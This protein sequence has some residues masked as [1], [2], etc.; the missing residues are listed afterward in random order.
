M[1]AKYIQQKFYNVC[2]DCL[3][4]IGRKTAVK[5][6][7]EEDLNIPDQLRTPVDQE[8]ESDS[9]DSNLSVSQ[10][11]DDISYV[12]SRDEEESTLQPKRLIFKTTREKQRRRRGQRRRARDLLRGRHA[13]E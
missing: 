8:E 13:H 2:P 4:S 5:F 6:S 3:L 7:G 1:N 10:K 9:D 12:D 11:D